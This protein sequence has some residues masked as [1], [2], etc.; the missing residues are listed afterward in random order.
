MRVLVVIAL[1]FLAAP[2]CARSEE[3]FFS[4]ASATLHAL[5]DRLLGKYRSNGNRVDKSWTVSDLAKPEEIRGSYFTASQYGLRFENGESDVAY[6]QF[7][8]KVKPYP[9]D[10]FVRVHL[11]TGESEFSYIGETWW[12][13]NED[14]I[15]QS[16][17]WIG[18][19][20]TAIVAAVWL[21]KR[22]NWFSR[23]LPKE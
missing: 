13:R 23:R 14:T 6:I 7:T 15:T 5:K 1:C 21:A 11:R 2:L 20:L 3:A 12:S 8:S 19:S 10:W 22:N 4:E 18:L 9:R 17:I 16:G